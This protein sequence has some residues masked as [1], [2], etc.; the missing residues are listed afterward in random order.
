MTA[1]LVSEL[2]TNSLRFASGP[3]GVRLVRPDG[4]RTCSSWRSPTLPD[5][6]C[7]PARRTPTTKGGRGLQLVAGASRAAGGTKPGSTGRRRKPCG[8]GW[9]YRVGLRG[10][11]ACRARCAE[12]GQEDPWPIETEG[13][14]TQV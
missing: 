9:L 6:P 11:W 3:I 14:D 7:A 2:V 10:R 13:E 8:F 4:S 12:A 5:P 1:L